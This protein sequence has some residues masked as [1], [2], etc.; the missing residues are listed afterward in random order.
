MQVRRRAK[1]TSSELFCMSDRSVIVVVLD[2]WGA[3]Q[4]APLGATMLEMPFINHLAA[5]SLTANFCFADSPDLARIYNSYWTAQHAAGES[6]SGDA[7]L[8]R[9]Q[10]ASLLITDEAL[11][12]D[13]ALAR[14]FEEKII[15]PAGA[16]ISADE[17]ADTQ[18]AKLLFAAGEAILSQEAPAITWVHA[19]TMEGPWDA[20]LELRRSL[21]D[22]DDP[23]TP[24]FVIPPSRII[25]GPKN[26]DEILGISQAYG[27]QVLALDE[28]LGQF[29]EILD[30]RPPEIVEN[31]LLIV[32]SPRGFPLGEHN[33]IG[34]A[35]SRLYSELLQVPLFV[36]LGRGAYGEA[37]ALQRTSAFV[38]PA[39]IGAT[40]DHW[41]HL[42]EP[43]HG[44][45]RSLIPLATYPDPAAMPPKSWR[46]AFAL[47]QSAAGHAEKYFT[48]PGWALRYLLKENDSEPTLELFAKPDDRWEVNEIGSRVAQATEAMIER[49][50]Q[51]ELA[52]TSGARDRLPDLPDLLLRPQ[53]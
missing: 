43:K 33:V 28:I 24:D 44:W 11:V 7:W 2:R 41:L 21:A 40:I 50:K 4:A 25:E 9:M 31:T 29:I 53:R 17:V 14:H 27:G 45:G 10:L 23:E 51:L 12:R 16:P 1:E 34:D 18:L 47:G 39:D 15:L 49:M 20:P 30:Q 13:H 32:T 52:I 36:R 35:Q 38:Q 6:G 46:C 19:Q 5:A 48:T 22:E 26:Y 8:A 42:E 37:G 3:G